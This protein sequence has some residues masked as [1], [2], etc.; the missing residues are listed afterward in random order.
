MKT[1]ELLN[2]MTDSASK[3]GFTA[4]NITNLGGIA[5]VIFSLWQGLGVIKAEQAALA[6]KQS[7]AFEVVERLSSK[8]DYQRSL[9][10]NQS[11]NIDEMQTDLSTLITDSVMTKRGLVLKQV[12]KIRNDPEDIKMADLRLAEQYCTAM[13]LKMPVES[14]NIVAGYNR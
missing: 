8:I 12:E 9:I 1:S 11:D 5:V 4:G 6:K 2:M 3:Q 14:C 7:E 13:P 10:N